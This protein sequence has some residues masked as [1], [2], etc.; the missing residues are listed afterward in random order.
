ML[1]HNW[2]RSP[3]HLVVFV[4]EEN[5]F[6]YFKREFPNLSSFGD[7]QRRGRGD[8]F[9]QAAGKHMHVYSSICVRSMHTGLTFTQMEHMY[10]CLSATHASEDVCVHAHPPFPEPGCKHLTAH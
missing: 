3:E 1:E 9:V 2:K 4:Y 10:M 7:Q 8:G 6:A 5:N